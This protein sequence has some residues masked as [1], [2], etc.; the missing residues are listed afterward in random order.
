M[1]SPTRS[2]AWKFFKRVDETTASFKLCF[3]TLKTIGNTSN[4]KKHME[5]HLSVLIVLEGG[6]QHALL[7]KYILYFICADKRPFDIVNGRVFKRL[8]KQLCPSFKIPNEGCLKEHL[9]Q[10]Y[11]VITEVYITKF[12]TSLRH[13]A[14]YI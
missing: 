12:S 14:L 5:M 9:D 2:D 11:D 6:A 10:M 13:V 8:I 4:L 1:I 3:K 7:T